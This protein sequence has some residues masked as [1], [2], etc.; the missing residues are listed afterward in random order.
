MTSS[1][2]LLIRP[3][4]E[5]EWPACRMLLP[6]M[7]ADGHGAECRLVIAPVSPFIVA[8]AAFRPHGSEWTALTLHVVPSF[9]RQGIG[10]AL[11]NRVADEAATDGVR[12]LRVWVDGGRDP[13]V[14]A[15]LEAHAFLV[16]ER[17][18]RVEGDLAAM[19]PPIRTFCQRLRSAGRIPPDVATS[20]LMVDDWDSVLAL[21]ADH[22]ASN[23]RLTA[24][25]LPMALFPHLLAH[26]A[27]LRRGGRIAGVIL[28]HRE[29][30]LVST[31][32][33]IVPT[34]GAAP[35]AAALLLAGSMESAWAAGARR[36]R[37]EFLADNIP[38]R[39]L[40]RRFGTRL[41]DVRSAMVRVVG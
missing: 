33:L 35:W 9:R 30:D 27:V 16:G 3:P 31:V 13:E 10:T 23:P 41:L 19:W 29:G 17:L 1:M 22:I 15:F 14:A 11:L 4:L 28:C 26:S 5:C 21:H 37:Y 7:F 24:G 25:G 40:T 20:A 6:A 38:M 12:A 18:C 34:G 39:N 36:A 32:A 8:A 2:N